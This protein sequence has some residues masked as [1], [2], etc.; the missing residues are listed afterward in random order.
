MIPASTPSARAAWRE[1]LHFI[2]GVFA[3]VALAVAFDRVADIGPANALALHGALQGSERVAAL[4]AA[5]AQH[6]KQLR[7]PF[8]VWTKIGHG[9]A[10]SSID[11]FSPAFD[12]RTVLASAIMA[13]GKKPWS[14]KVFFLHA[15]FQIFRPIVGGIL[16]DMHFD[17]IIERRRT[18]KCFSNK[19][20]D[21]VGHAADNHDKAGVLFVPN[22]EGR[23]PPPDR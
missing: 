15:P 22:T 3:L 4:A 10:P 20:R 5:G 11:C 2:F 19:S 9:G 8:L 16:V 18:M 23:L 1:L 21:L 14:T 6:A 17:C 7:D 13:I 12:H